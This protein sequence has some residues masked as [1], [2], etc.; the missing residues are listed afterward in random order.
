MTAEIEVGDEVAVRVQVASVGT[1]GIS[2]RGRRKDGG[3]GL[4]RSALNEDVVLPARDL[5]IKL[6]EMAEEESDAAMKDKGTYSDGS[7]SYG[8]YWGQETAY[9]EV[10]AWIEEMLS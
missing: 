2:V 3:F 7:E 10:V 6:K 8:Y 4:S 5:L 9:D 1:D